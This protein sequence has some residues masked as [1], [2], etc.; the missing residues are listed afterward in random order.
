MTRVYKLLN[1][2]FQYAKKQKKG[3]CGL[4][5]M[6]WQSS[7]IL[8]SCSSLLFFLI[9]FQFLIYFLFCSLCFSSF[10]LIFNYGLAVN[11]LYYVAVCTLYP[12]SLQDF[13]HKMVLGFAKSIF[14]VLCDFCLSVCLHGRLNLL[15]YVY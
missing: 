15:F 8:S 11:C 12:K 7:Y 14:Y 10:K 13:Y 5:F 9:F 1:N 3:G 4:F 2:S 6:L